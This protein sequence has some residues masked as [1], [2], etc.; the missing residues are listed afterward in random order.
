MQILSFQ[1]LNRCKLE[2]GVTGH[3]GAEVM[4]QYGTEF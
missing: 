3:Y 4:G 2:V 1:G